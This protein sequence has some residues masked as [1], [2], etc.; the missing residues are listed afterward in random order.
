MNDC[1]DSSLVIAAVA[2]N[3]PVHVSLSKSCGLNKTLY[4]CIWYLRGYFFL[5]PG[6][7]TCRNGSAAAG[8]AAECHCWDMPVFHRRFPSCCVQESPPCSCLRG[9]WRGFIWK[10]RGECRLQPILMETLWLLH[11]KNIHTNLHVNRISTSYS[12]G[13][14]CGSVTHSGNIHNHLFFVFSLKPEMTF[15]L[16]R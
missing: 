2:L 11:F 9:W 6:T 4:I 3:F 7:E 1:C 16:G 12:A 10:T 14:R 15:S 13:S 8:S 5:L